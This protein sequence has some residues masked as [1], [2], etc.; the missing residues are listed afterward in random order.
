MGK[1]TKKFVE[2][3]NESPDGTVDLNNASKQLNVQ[4]RRIYDITNV[5]EG[6]GLVQKEHKNNIKWKPEHRLPDTN[7]AT[8]K[9]NQ[10]RI[11]LLQKEN[12]LTH[13]LDQV[14]EVISNHIADSQYAYIT[15]QDIRGTEKLHDQTVMIVKAPPGAVL[16]V[17][18]HQVLKLFFITIEVY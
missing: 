15:Q 17:R 8:R 4:K 2:L 12:Y 9:V 1:L 5:L 7:E 3:I 13:L 11:R 14:K 18:V 16:T 6:I 10:E